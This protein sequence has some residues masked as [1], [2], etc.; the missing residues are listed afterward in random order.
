MA[1]EKTSHA[2]PHLP[3]RLRQYL[4]PSGR[5]IHIAPSPDAADTL[6]K[7]LSQDPSNDQ[8]DVH[9]QGSPEH[10]DAIQQLRAH[11]EG[12]RDTLRR[13]H[14]PLYDQFEDVRRELDALAADLQATSSRPVAL[15]ANFDRFGYSAHIRTH[16]AQVSGASTPAGERA[17]S[18]APAGSGVGTAEDAEGRDRRSAAQTVKV[19]KRPVVRQYWHKGF[20]WRSSASFE[21]APFELFIDLLYVGII[22]ILGDAAAENPTGRGLLEF[23]VLFTLAYKLWL[24]VTLVV[25]WFETGD[26]TQRASILFYMACLIGYT[27]NIEDA[28]HGTYTEL[29]AFYLANRL[30][31]AVYYCW[32]ALMVPMIRGMMVASAILVVIPAALW[33]GSIHIDEPNRWV[34]IWFALAMDLFG[35]GVVIPFVRWSQHLERGPLGFLALR[36]QF[37]P[38][39]NIEHKTERMGNDPLIPYHRLL[40]DHAKQRQGLS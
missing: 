22:G 23:A 2:S 15:D 13:Q 19:W 34:A 14:G 31:E 6:R 32:I 12:R 37:Y 8:F 11:H 30:F 9:I 40:K 29:I 20:I 27:I 26:L 3:Q 36:L 17:L 28:F 10:L 5:K 21:V 18:T 16:E 7:Q 33:I 39:I 24:D 1:S 25:A 4:H 38:A 35:L